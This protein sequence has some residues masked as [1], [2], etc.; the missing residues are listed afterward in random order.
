MKKIFSLF[1][2]ASVAL[3]GLTCCGGGGGGSSS[4]EVITVQ[5]FASAAKMYKL[6]NRVYM[7]IKPVAKTTPGEVTE[8]TATVTV[9]SKLIA[10]KV[11]TGADITYTRENEE[12]Y[13][14]EYS[15][16]TTEDLGEADLIAGFGFTPPSTDSDGPQVANPV[17][18]LAE[19]DIRTVIDV[20]AHTASTIG[21][22]EVIVN[23]ETN[24]K[25]WQTSQSPNKAYEVL[26][27]M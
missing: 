19:K 20:A 8:D 9:S 3:L 21:S 23:A 22:C 26:P 2:T 27:N 10:G 1:A 16:E 12:T 11:E 14:L 25:E 18:S 7:Y 4:Y 15:F 5:E 17:V 24:A 13:T 6:N